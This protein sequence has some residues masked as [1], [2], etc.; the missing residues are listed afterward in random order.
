[1]SYNKLQ[2]FNNKLKKIIMADLT[3]FPIPNPSMPTLLGKK[4]MIHDLTQPEATSTILV[5]F[6]DLKIRI[7]EQTQNGLSVIGGN[8]ELGG[9]IIKPTIINLDNHQFLISNSPLG[10]MGFYP[11]G[12]LT[13]QFVLICSSD[14]NVYST[15]NTFKDTTVG[16]KSIGC[17]INITDNANITGIQMGFQ[18]IYYE[19]TQDFQSYWKYT[20]SVLNE[21]LFCFLRRDTGFTIE[22]ANQGLSNNFSGETIFN[23]KDFLNNSTFF[24]ATP[25]G[26]LT[27]KLP[28]YLTDLDADNDANL[29]N[30]GLYLLIGGRDIKVKP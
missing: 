2:S 15:V 9:L 20:N 28:Q 7:Q 13:E 8:T 14:D 21:N 16:N 10:A 18:N 30:L 27:A 23:I 5:N 11:F 25:N 24:A 17:G 6:E 3:V 19:N 12:T 4:I 22:Q 1:M 26:Y 29:P